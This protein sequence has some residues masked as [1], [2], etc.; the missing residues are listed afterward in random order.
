MGEKNTKVIPLTVKYRPQ[1]LDEVVGRDEIIASLRRRLKE[2]TLR[3]VLFEGVQGTGKTLIA[4]LLIRE[5]QGKSYNTLSHLVQ[6]ASSKN[7]VEEIKAN[8]LAYMRASLNLDNTP[9]IIFLDEADNLSA[10]SQAVLRRP[11][12]KYESICWTFMACNFANKIIQPLHSR[13]TVYH[14][15]EIEQKYVDQFILKILDKEGIRIEGD[16]KDL[17]NQIYNYGKGEIRFILN[18]FIEEARSK[19]VL[20]QDVID[21]FTPINRTYAELLFKG[22]V[23][24]AINIA[25][26]NPKGTLTGAIDYIYDLNNLRNLSMKGRVKLAEWFAEGLDSAAHGVP[27][28]VIIKHLS[29]KVSLA[30]NKGKNS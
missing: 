8:V 20:N 3:H 19:G 15:G 13:C 2:G 22:Q 1:T 27:Y 21:L 28:Y 9:K 18:N 5:V 12:E 7:K 29:H 4:H 25:Y 11:L 24:R 17:L 16:T 14:F 23:E 30:L 10:S 6:D 26:Q